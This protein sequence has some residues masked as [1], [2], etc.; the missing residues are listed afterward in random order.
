MKKERKAFWTPFWA[1]LADVAYQYRRVFKVVF[2]AF[3]VVYL[4]SAI[5]FLGLRYVVLPHVNVYKSE[6][7]KLASESVGQ[8]VRF[9]R[10]DA[11]WYGLRPRIDLED[12]VLSDR[13]GH[14]A[15]RLKKVTAVV[16]WWSLPLLDVRLARLQLDEPD[17]SV[18][19]DRQGRIHVA[20]MRVD[21]EEEDEGGL[22]DWLL[23]QHEIVV[24]DGK[25][26][27]KDELRDN[28][29][30]EFNQV[31]LVMKNRGRRHRFRLLA[32][33]SPA[34]MKNVDIR[35][36]LLHPRFAARTADV[37]RWQGEIYVSVLDTD[38]A[39]WKKFVD[40]PVELNRG[41]GS[42]AAWLTI[43]RSQLTGVTADVDGEDVQLRLEAGLPLLDLSDLSG[44][45]SWHKLTH[46]P[47]DEGAG[48]RPLYTGGID[49]LT[50]ET[51]Q[52]E[53]LSDASLTVRYEMDQQK[54]PIEVEAEAAHLNVGELS[55]F[56]P[57]LP[58]DP[59]MRQRIDRYEVAGIL[60]RFSVSWKR[61]SED[62]SS[63]LVEGRFEE[64][65]LRDKQKNAR[66]KNP[67][68][69]EMLPS[70]FGVENLTGFVSANEYG[71]S[72]DL[73]SSRVALFLPFYDQTVPRR[74]DELTA[75]LEWNRS[76]KE[77]LSVDV[78]KLSLRHN[79]M[80][81]DVGGRYMKDLSDKTDRYGSVDAWAKIKNLALSDVGKYVP[82]QTPRSLKEWLS[83]AIKGGRVSEGAVQIKGNLAG[84]PYAGKGDEGLF[85]VRA[86]LVDGV[87]DYAPNTFSGNERRPL[88][89]LIDHIQGEFRMNGPLLAIHADTASTRQVGL[90]NVDVVI[91]DVLADDPV[92]DVKG[93][94]HGALQHFVGFVNATPVAEWINHLTQA[95][96]ASGNAG[97]ALKLQLPLESPEKSTVAGTV[98]FDNNDIVL[99]EN[100]PVIS[101]TR[102]QLDF[103][104]NGFRLND[105]K[106]RFLHEPVTIVGGTHKDGRFLVRADGLLS[107]KGLQQ[108]YPDG[109]LGKLME[110]LSGS[111][112]YIVT[113]SNDKIRIESGLKGL[114]IGLPAPLGKQ[115]GNTVLLRVSLE[116]LPSSEGMKQ[117]EINIAY[118][119]DMSARYLRQKTSQQDTWQVIQ[120]GIGI[121]KKPEL[122]KGTSLA[123]NLHSIDFNEWIDVVSDFYGAS[124][125][126]SSV[127]SGNQG[128][129]PYLEP[130]YFSIEADEMTAMETWLTHATLTGVRQSGYWDVNVVSD[131]INGQL[132][133]I[134]AGGKLAEGKLVARL[135]S[136]NILQSS[137]K[138]VSDVSGKENITR[139]P[140]LDMVA[141][142]LTLFGKHLGKT[143]IV[144]N[145]VP[146]QGGREWRIN[147]LKITNPDAQLEASGSWITS[148]GSLQQT[149]LNYVLDIKN[150][151][152]LLDRFGYG[153]VIRRGHGEMKGDVSW[154]GLPFALDIP[155]LSGKMSLKLEAGQF[156]KADPGAAK[157]LSVISLQSL[158]RRLSLDFRDIFS[159]GF[160]FDEITAN[161]QIT[162]GIMRTENLKM[163]GVNATVLMDGSVDIAKESQDLHVVVIPEINAAAASIAYGF[164]NPA[165]GIGT[166]LAQMFLREP[167]MKQ[168]THEYRVTG[169]W[170]DPVIREVKNGS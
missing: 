125:P 21:S 57:Y 44:R 38:V 152:K 42:I 87:L 166:F 35:G 81:L 168:F 155:S 74:F 64:M 114:K 117:D 145:N 25:L 68:G 70:G 139:I 101:K 163:N 142:D 56:L 95:T 50:L 154:S 6:I 89:P 84:F 63:Y 150:A 140:A 169:S 119:P 27:W 55:R 36:D 144:A 19:R 31:N 59:G 1:A 129:V 151:G 78:K 58:L 98:Q 103:S 73:D 29:R 52:G 2:G 133:W 72:L 109:T 51:V 41:Q 9:S 165:I 135:K 77:V 85:T 124:G 15:L 32:E 8:P 115:A 138:K 69:T 60:S 83:S 148:R 100:L 127:S 107:A 102:G 134:E 33:T 162:D 110:K 45:F 130:R 3:F 167:L 61:L 7:E 90:K 120:G 67:P 14:E 147:R 53:R 132:K 34:L 39:E 76:R 86:R 104:E 121:N 91:P 164:V 97:L 122:K 113:V 54:R 116:D 71:G 11:C 96:V 131:Q 128:I 22:A 92:L 93:D 159:K 123:L 160:A 149:R 88:W 26:R 10:I 49:H 17:V 47:G 37:S 18:L 16:S 157:L 156:L 24:H 118:G 30:L 136:L 79:G 13:E 170:S 62:R 5:V 23:K 28:A 12:V 158:P 153:E 137:L 43:D 99:L 161:A 126:Q 94:A 65:T 108:T 46:R 48:E 143:E 40:F 105:L 106:A 141:D 80:E 4:V 66:L 82:L 146:F 20:G 75:R 112:P 111:T